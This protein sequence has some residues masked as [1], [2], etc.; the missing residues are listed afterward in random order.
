VNVLAVVP[1]YVPRSRVGAWITTHEYLAELV[2]R[3]HHVDVLQLMSVQPGYVIDGVHV[4]PKMWQQYTPHLV[5]SHL[6]DDGEG[7]EYA[8]AQG[9]P[10]VRMVHGY[11]PDNIER[12]DKH[13]TALAVF[14]SRTLANDTA[15]PGNQLVAHPPIH[16]EKFRTTPGQHVTLSN[17]S[18]PKGGELFRLL[19][20]ALPTVPFL[21]VKGGYGRQE[22]VVP[23]NVT[24][25]PMVEDVRAVFRRTRILLMPSD[26]ESYGRM[27]VEAAC[28]GIP[29]I[30]HPCDGL[31]EA[32][33]DRA[34]WCDRTD[35][36]T[37]I[38]AVRELQDDNRWAQA[39]E[40][41]S[42]VAGW[43]E[44]DQ[45]IKRVVDAIEELCE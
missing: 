11:K 31:R 36:G 15:W 42:A 37:W 27:A 32:L 3:G 40:S 14:S 29:T 33:G 20:S 28:S 35:L 38:K 13:P 18:K 23:Q 26:Y 21:G 43:L 24:I 9:I 10:S 2:L 41:A 1:L 8:E 5:V 19:A 6:G 12:L 22:R 44:P 16:P 7:A 25:M 30:A 39:S 4:H 45:T 17:L 34:I